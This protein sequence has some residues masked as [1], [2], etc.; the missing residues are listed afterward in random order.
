MD[1]MTLITNLI[2]M[3]V[4]GFGMY[5]AVKH[6]KGKGGSIVLIFF[7]YA[8]I[9]YFLCDLYTIATEAIMPN[10]R[11]PFGVDAV[12]EMGEC[13]L[14]ASLLNAVFRE[15][16]EN[17]LIETMLSIIFSAAMT[18]LWIAWS[19]EWTKDIL[20]GVY[21]GYF[22]YIGV[23]S[24]KK[25]HAF[26]KKSGVILGVL[27]YTVIAAH[28]LVFFVPSDYEEITNNV[29][30]VLMF[31]GIVWLTIVAIIYLVKAVRGDSRDEAKKAVSTGFFALIWTMNTMF[32]SA[33]IM[34]TIAEFI[35]SLSLLII[36]YDVI[37]LEEKKP[38]VIVERRANRS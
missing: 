31:S 20:G 11:L 35:C 6:M 37:T 12:A 22:I 7:I 32:M 4:L 15:S 16:N 27:A 19:G 30:Y 2:Q 1:V 18:A 26:S 8:I 38:K 23:I 3:V 25:S 14:M 21:F 36:V 9:C 33:D 13:L 10:T 24:L 28:T 34:Y 17:L 29:A 5:E